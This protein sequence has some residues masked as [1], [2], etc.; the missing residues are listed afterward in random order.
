MDT[1]VI[2]LRIGLTYLNAHLHSLGMSDSL[3]LP[4]LPYIAPTLTDLLG[5]ST[6]SNL[7]FKTLNFTRTVLQKMN[8]LHHI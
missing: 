2:R 1:A 7:A 5:S 6:N 8:Q 3:Q 4:L